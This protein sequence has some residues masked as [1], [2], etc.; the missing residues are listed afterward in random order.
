MENFTHTTNSWVYVD[1]ND[2]AI[3]YYGSWQVEM[4]LQTGLDALTE[5]EST[6]TPIYGTLHS[7]TSDVNSTS[8]YSFWYQFNGVSAF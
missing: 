8:P 6:N 3:T 2:P 4:G 7:T 5:P 1:N